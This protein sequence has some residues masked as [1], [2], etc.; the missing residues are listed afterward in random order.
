MS[1]CEVLAK[2]QLRPAP[3]LLRYRTATFVM[4]STWNGTTSVNDCASAR[5]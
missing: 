1:P 5:R 4:M 2:P 3:V